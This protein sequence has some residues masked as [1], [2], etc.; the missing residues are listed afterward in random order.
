MRI[1]QNR[2]MICFIKSPPLRRLIW[3]H[4]KTESPRLRQGYNDPIC[5]LVGFEIASGRLWRALLG[6]CGERSLR[7]INQSRGYVGP[8]R[9]F[10][11]R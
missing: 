10:A 6:F 3:W 7:P 2:F 11:A 8:N 5:Q 1:A 4:A 9:A